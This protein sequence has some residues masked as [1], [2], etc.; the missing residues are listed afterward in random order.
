MILH[1]FV[2]ELS[3]EVGGS[4][5]NQQWANAF[6]SSD[7]AID[8]PGFQTFECISDGLSNSYTQGRWCH[9]HSGWQRRGF[10]LWDQ[11][12]D[13]KHTKHGFKTIQWRTGMD[14]INF[15]NLGAGNIDDMIL[16]DNILLYSNV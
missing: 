13:L 10:W 5:L 3:A 14:H 4:K 6:W 7:W 16:Y 1:A 11:Q 8:D 2:S 15:Q 9:Q 12:H